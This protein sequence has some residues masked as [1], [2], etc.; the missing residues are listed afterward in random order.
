MAEPKRIAL[1]PGLT[2]I[3][4]KGDSQHPDKVFTEGSTVIGLT[5]VQLKAMLE[6][7]EEEA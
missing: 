4:V 7:A 6:L 1:G 5:S 3:F 2:A